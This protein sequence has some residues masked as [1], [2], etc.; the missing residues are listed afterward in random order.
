MTHNLKR[1]LRKKPTPTENEHVILERLITHAEAIESKNMVSLW[2]KFEK[3]YSQRVGDN[4]TWDN[5]KKLAKLKDLGD[6]LLDEKPGD[7]KV[8]PALSNN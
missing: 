1:A 3:I 7:N 6:W 5:A 4:L 2:N 8:T